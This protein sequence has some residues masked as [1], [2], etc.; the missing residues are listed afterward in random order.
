M[1]LKAESSIAGRKFVKRLSDEREI[2]KKPERADQTRMV[3]FGLIGAKFAFGEIVDVDQ[4]GPCPLRKPALFRAV[5]RT[6]SGVS[7]VKVLQSG[8]WNNS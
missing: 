1:R 8:C 7:V 5:A 2:G 3:G 6:S 4:V